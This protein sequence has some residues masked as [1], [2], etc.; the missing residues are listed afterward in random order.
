MTKTNPLY[1]S[2]FHLLSING[3][4]YLVMFLISVIIFRTV[5]KDYYGLYVILLSLFAMT[6]LLMAGL[7]D[8]IV[9]F[10]DDKISLKEKQSIVLFVLLYKYLLIFTFIIFAY[11]ASK[12][13]FF[14]FLIGN[15]NEISSVIN[16]FLIVVILNGVLSNFI[17]VN[18]CV[19]NSQKEYKFTAKAEFAR[20]VVS[21]IVV[22]TLSFFT[23]NYLHYLYSSIVISMFMLLFLALRISRDFNSFSLIEVLKVKTNIEIGKKYIFPYSIPLTGSSILTYVKNNLPTLI[24]G[25]EFSLEGVAI[26]SILKNLFKALHS[27][28]GSF[29]SP[30]MAQFLDLKQYS[31]KFFRSLNTIFFGILF[32]R[33]SLYIVFLFLVDY[34]FLLYKLTDTEVNKFIFYVLGIEFII[35]GMISTYGIILRLETNTRKIL[36]ASLVRFVIEIILIYFILLE[37][38]VMGAA[39]ILLT[40][41]YVE[42]LVTYIYARNNT[43]FPFSWLL[44]I[45]FFLMIIFFF[46]RIQII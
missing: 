5:A 3:L 2:I 15:Y 45:L 46:I 19:L 42:T 22:F 33:I 21:L 35:A 28:T 18:N 41:R 12:F 10:L 4:S 9:R 1:K 40:A 27:V 14:K 20:N 32:L 25:K 31:N 8:C 30:M 26:F 39:L 24:L 11:I 7:N 17:S 43:L 38:G 13:G 23:T 44:F 36:N 6:E 16:S 29:V 34:L 37:Y